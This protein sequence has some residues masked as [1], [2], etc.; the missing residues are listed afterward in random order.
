MQSPDIT[1][2]LRPMSPRHAPILRLWSELGRLA[3]D[4][5]GAIGITMGVMSTALV[6]VGGMAIDVSDWYLTRRGMQSAA[7]AAAVAGAM[8]LATGGTN[9]QV[10]TLA[11]ADATRNSFGETN[12]ATVNVTP[13]GVARTVKVDIT[14]PATLYLAS[15]F[16]PQAPLI[17]ATA[18]AGI[19]PPGTGAPVCV[20]ALSPT[21]AG[22]ITVN[23]NGTIQAPGC[24]LVSNSTSPTAL[25]ANGNATIT[26]SKT[27]MPGGYTTSGN[28]HLTPMPTPCAA[29][30]DP[31]A[32]F[33]PPPGAA[34]PCNHTN[35]SLG[36]NGSATLNPGV[37]CGGITLNGNATVTLNPGIYVLRNGG[38]EANGNSTTTG[39][40]VAFYLSGVGASI[41][42]ANA[43]VDLDGNA[44]LNITAPTSGPMA[45]IAVYQDDFAATGTITHSIV[46]NGQQNFSGTVYF[47]NQN[48]VITGNGTANS[49]APFTSVIAN[50]INYNGNG[51]LY[52]NANY[53][54]TTIPQVSGLEVPR[55]VL[56]Q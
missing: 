23:G 45:G 54:N 24:A 39:N 31:L 52:F 6:G 12:G 11:K 13:D 26:T 41:N 25:V 48:L 36:G 4:K 44:V 47:G 8:K 37:Y 32:N 33:P 40:G 34:G 49:Q 7:D 14:R 29:V 56:L 1:T 53:N 9:Q 42:L 27:C 28:A 46:G 43:D 18:T 55:I 21:A 50:T 51:T 35:Y 30:V 10:I 19:A 22:A 16:L 5:T 3:R 17:S 38:F 2:E 20:L 15:L